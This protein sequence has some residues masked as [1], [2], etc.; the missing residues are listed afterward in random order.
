MLKRLLN[1]ESF[2]TAFED[3]KVRFLLTTCL[4]DER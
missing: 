4:P 1:S 2:E 3:G